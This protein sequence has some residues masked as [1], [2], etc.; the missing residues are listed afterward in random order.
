MTDRPA[1][2]FGLARRGRV[3]TGCFAD[4][5]VFDA[6]RVIDTATYDDPRQFPSGIP[7]VVVNGRVAVDRERCTGV[8]AGQ[9]VP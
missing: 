4:V 3:E 8:V 2:R 9:A 1:R 7:F 6:G 5:V